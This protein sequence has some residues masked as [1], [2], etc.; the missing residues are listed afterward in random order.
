MHDDNCSV[1]FVLFFVFNKDNNILPLSLLLA[2][3]KDNTVKL[4]IIFHN[5]LLFPDLFP[6]L[7]KNT[8]PLVFSP[9]SY[10]VIWTP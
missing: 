10:R 4:L 1:F 7:T 9:K 8:P 6:W 2:S 3:Y 5:S